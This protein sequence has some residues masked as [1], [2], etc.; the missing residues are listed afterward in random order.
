MG[1]TIQSGN[2]C[3]EEDEEPGGPVKEIA[4]CLSVIDPGI[5]P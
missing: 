3:D 4:E 2:V 5:D 1:G